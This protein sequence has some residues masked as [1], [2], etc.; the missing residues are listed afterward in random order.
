MNA[1]MEIVRPGLQTIVV[2]APRTGHRMIGVGLGGALDVASFA[3]AN[4]LVGNA[5]D[6]PA[7]EIAYGAFMARCVV[8]MHLGVSGAECAV[9]FDGVHLV[10][11][12]PLSGVRCYVAVQGGFDVPAALG[13][14]TTDLRGGFGGWH[15]RA[16]RATDVLP[17]AGD[18]VIG[19]KLEMA[20][21]PYPTSA[22]VR[23][24]DRHAPPEFWAREWSVS[25][26]S[27]RMGAR[28]QGDALRG[29]GDVESHAVFPGVVQ[30][31]ADGQPIVLLADA[32]TTG[33]YRAIASV[34][35]ADL[36][37]FAQ[38]PAGATVRFEKWAIDDAH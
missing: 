30:L 34:I 21:Q 6:T 28:L 11:E 16:L 26:A 13:S 23:A 31:P 18:E 15:G 1:T 29:G 5:P 3:R 14:R 37:A 25:P 24:I 12:P 9:R 22:V 20:V 33:G 19:T 36:N 2:A 32:Q 38:L 17:I 10:V 7:L 35:T 8:P 27:S 4:A